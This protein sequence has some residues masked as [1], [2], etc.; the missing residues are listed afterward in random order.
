LDV[1]LGDVNGDG[2]IDILDAYAIGQEYEPMLM[3]SESTT[4]SA[5]ITQDGVVNYADMYFVM[6][7]YLMQDLTRT[8]SKVPEEFYNGYDLYDVL[9]SCGYFDEDTSL[10]V[11]LLLSEDVVEAGTSVDFTA[12]PPVD[13]VPFEYEFS[14]REV[15]DQTWTV[16]KARGSEA[17]TT[18]TPE[19]AG[20][21]SVKVRIFYDEVEYVWQDNKMLTVTP[22]PV[23]I[24]EAL[25]DLSSSDYYVAGDGSISAPLELVVGEDAEEAIA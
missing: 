16:V 22:K 5:D 7:N 8:D 1:Y 15:N 25:D 14:V 10:N 4:S 21:Y 20:E 24:P 9:E 2:A 17:T 6:M 11:E 18:W 3:S 12:I 13:Y 19:V 23:V